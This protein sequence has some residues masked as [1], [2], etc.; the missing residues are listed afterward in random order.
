MPLGG[1][2]LLL[3]IEKSIDERA[4]DIAHLSKP[5]LCGFPP[6]LSGCVYNR[7]ADGVMLLRWTPSRHYLLPRGVMQ[8]GKSRRTWYLL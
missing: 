2:R 4:A 1:E 3:A 6:P 8:R 7:A 5:A